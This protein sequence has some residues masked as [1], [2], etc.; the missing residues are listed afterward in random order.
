MASLVDIECKVCGVDFEAENYRT[1]MCGTCSRQKQL[2][3][4]KKYKKKNKEHVQEY[5]KIYKEEHKEDIDVYNRLYNIENRQEIQE[6][7]TRT[8]RERRKNDPGFNLLHNI[9]NSFGK[10]LKSKSNNHSDHKDSIRDIVGCSNKYLRSWL[11]SQ[12][13]TEMSWENYGTFWH[14]DHIVLCSL[15]NFVEYEERKACFNWQNTRP[16]KA[17]RNYKRKKL[18]V[19]DLLNQEIRLYYF[20]NHVDDSEY[21]QSYFGTKLVMKIASGLS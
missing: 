6:R 8:H 1:K 15:F 18:C 21:Q 20:K 3:R 9:R 10:Y 16:L 5:N 14:A 13:T 11:E 7:Q 4:C 12:F 2:D 19:R 17:M